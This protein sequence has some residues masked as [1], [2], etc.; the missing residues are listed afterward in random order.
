VSSHPYRCYAKINL[1]LE[2]L[3]RRSDG[4]HDLAS[5]AHTISLADDLR[6]AEADEIVCRA[7]GLPVEPDAN[8]VVRAAKLLQAWTR[9]S[10]GAELTLDKHIP[11]AAGLGGGST[12]AAATLVALNTLW[13]THLG[14]ADLVSLAAQLGSDVP[15]FIRGGAAVLRGRGDDL[16]PV[17]P[18]VGQWLTLAAPPHD[19]ANKTVTLYA[20]LA[21]DDFTDGQ[22]T[23]QAA[24]HLA[25]GGPLDGARLHN[26]FGRAA[27]EVFAGLAE[28]WQGAEAACGR[29]FHL[30]GAGPTLFALASGRHDAQRLLPILEGLG[31]RAY[32]VRTVGHARA[33]V[34]AG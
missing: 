11:V 13:G 21:P 34:T 8:L 28:V 18:L 32:A 29:A 2:V 31:V 15:F 33:S 3:G 12:D 23:R 27:R 4:Y 7:E 5:L 24:A 6:V 20:A 26:A 9:V 14:S 16:T 19:L 17:Q 1:T 30:S 25:E 22:A 10:A